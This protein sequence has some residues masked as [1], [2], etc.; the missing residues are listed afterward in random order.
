[1]RGDI[2]VESEPG[3]GS[4]FSFALRL[5][6]AAGSAESPARARAGTGSGGQAPLSILVVDDHPINRDVARAM[7]GRLGYP[8]ELAVDGPE[9]VAAVGRRDY[10]IVFMDLHMPGM[11]GLQTTRLIQE[12]TATAP[13]RAP[14]VIAVTAIGR[15]SKE[16]R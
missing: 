10:D 12:A 14:H 15:L 9:A 3:R 2:H 8:A 5:T 6:R 16:A 7:L 4:V 13:R 1:M 11:S